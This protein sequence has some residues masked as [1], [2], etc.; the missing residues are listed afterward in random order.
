MWSDAGGALI[1]GTLLTLNFD[2]NFGASAVTF[3][4]GCEVT[5]NGLMMYPTTFNDGSIS[6]VVGGPEIS[7]PTLTGTVGQ[8]IDFPVTA[9]NFVMDVG[10]ISLFIGYNTGVLT[11]TGATDGVLSNYYINA[12]P[13]S[14]LG[15]QWADF[16]GIMF[17]ND[18]ILFTLHFTYNGGVSDLTFDAGCEFAQT[19]LTF[20]PVSYFD[21][22]VISGSFFDLK[23][24]LEGPY[25]GAGMNAY[26]YGLNLLP[27]AHP[28][29][30]APWNYAGTESVGAIP[31]ANVVDWVLVEI[32]ETPGDA[33]TATA[34]TMVAQQAAFLLDDGSIVDLDGSSNILVPMAFTDSV[35]VVVYHRNH[36]RVMSAVAVQMV[37]GAYEYDF[38]ADAAKSYGS[39]IKDLGGVYGMYASDIDNDGEVF[40]GDLAI[41]LNEYP[42]FGAYI[43]SDLD[44]DGETFAADL[45]FLLLNYPTFT[46]IP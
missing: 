1:D 35:F 17:A 46:A 45:N 3:E 43:N 34:A 31:N 24:Y 7:L 36:V 33:N 10:A 15:V 16:N 37:G 18:D 20:I 2:Y 6:P 23:V 30:A 32:R 38:T 12:M 21:G 29:N 4:G 13:N 19:D 14:Q 26:L 28:Y 27:L 42:T 41:F 44:L 8:N 9:N 11:Y 39:Q 5:D 22:G 25:N 40:V